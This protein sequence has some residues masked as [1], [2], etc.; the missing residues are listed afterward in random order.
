METPLLDPLDD[1]FEELGPSVSSSAVS[2]SGMSSEM[3][4][5]L[6]PLPH[7]LSP[8]PASSDGDGG[9]SDSDSSCSGDTGSMMDVKISHPVINISK[10]TLL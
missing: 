6:S 3:D 8:L 1:M 9:G 7:T 10:F 4:Q 2:D 5:Q